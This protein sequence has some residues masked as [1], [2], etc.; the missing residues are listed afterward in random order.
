MIYATVANR[1][2][3][4]GAFNLGRKTLKPDLLKYRTVMATK[5]LLSPYFTQVSRS[6]GRASEAA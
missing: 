5:E 6:T 1:M 2:L 3:L 4:W